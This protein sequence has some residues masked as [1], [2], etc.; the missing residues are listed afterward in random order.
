MCYKT[1]IMETK[2]WKRFEDKTYKILSDMN[3]DA[4][5]IKNVKIEG[6][7]SKVGRQIDVALIDPTKYK[8]LAFECKDWARSI[9]VNVVG[10]FNSVLDD[11]GTRSGAIVAN[12]SFSPAAKNMARSYGID[13][14]N[15]VDTSTQDIKT[16]LYTQIFVE[17][18]SVEGFGIKLDGFDSS[19]T[20]LQEDV[21]D[22]IIVN[23]DGKHEYAYELFATLWN[24]F[25]KLNKLSGN[26]QY[27]IPN[28]HKFID[29]RG[30]TIEINAMCFVYSAK[31][32]FYF[33]RLSLANTSGLYNVL[34]ESYKTTSSMI[35]PLDFTK[36]L[37]TSKAYT[38]SNARVRKQNC[39]MGVTILSRIPGITSNKRI[40]SSHM[41]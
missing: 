32:K 3:P 24:D 21:R 14:L 19:N 40:D 27:S 7:L 13:L 20:I 41:Q 1:Y 9:D 34:D 5:V 12:S 33:D 25:D 17:H 15:L 23:D 18:V 26:Y 22:V 30:D 2:R 10:E 29:G 4:E 8:F 6:K 37:N 36:I 31:T 38:G 11:I 28:V 16:K 35:G 39:S